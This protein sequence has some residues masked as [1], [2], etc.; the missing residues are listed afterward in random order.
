MVDVV[1]QPQAIG[2]DGGRHC[3][4][5]DE[6]EPSAN[7]DM[8]FIAEHR[9]GIEG[10]VSSLPEA[11]FAADLERLQRA[12]VSFCAAL[13]PCCSSSVLRRLEL[14]TARHR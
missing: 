8:G 14:G 1:V 11:L 12:F 6:A 9:N 7:T 4:R 10:D 2:V 13:I 3:S 5:A